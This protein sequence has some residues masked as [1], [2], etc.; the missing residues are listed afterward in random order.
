MAKKKISSFHMLLILKQRPA[1]Q[2]E[3]KRKWQN[4]LLCGVAASGVC[5]SGQ[6]GESQ[7][8]DHAYPD[9]TRR[10]M[11]HC[12]SHYKSDHE[13]QE[14]QNIQCKRH[15]SSRAVMMQPACQR[16]QVMIHLSLSGHW[17]SGS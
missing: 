15:R 16:G 2:T 13:D 11:Q 5:N 12:G 9:P 6:H 4:L 17:R 8:D 7:Q 14:A 10:D 3:T 1:S